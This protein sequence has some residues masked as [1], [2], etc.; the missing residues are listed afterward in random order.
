M[1]ELDDID[2]RLL[3]VLRNK[4]RIPMSSLADAVGIGRATTY[5][6]LE[7]LRASGVLEGFSAQVNAERIGLGI[8]AFI[9][10]STQQPQLSKFIDEIKDM[11]QIQYAARVTG[12]QDVL[13]LVRVPDIATLRDGILDRL[14][15]LPMVSGL[16]TFLI[17]Q[18]IVRHPYVL[19]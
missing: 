2:F 17:L 13:L 15:A 12:G 19:P 11:P 7:K 4:G 14:H 5:N 3:E 8:S 18:E 9:E 6:R 1:V 10:V 16:R